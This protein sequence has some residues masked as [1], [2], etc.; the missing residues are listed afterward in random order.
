MKPATKHE[1]ETN[2]L[3]AIALVLIVIVVI[4]VSGITAYY[5]MN[6]S[7]T[8]NKANCT[9]NAYT[10]LARGSYSNGTYGTLTI[11]TQTYPASFTTTFSQAEQSGHVVTTTIYNLPDYETVA[12]CTYNP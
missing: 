10:I 11:S 1:R 7:A 12:T 4:A 3:S 5:V 2:G 9:G 8:T 6:N